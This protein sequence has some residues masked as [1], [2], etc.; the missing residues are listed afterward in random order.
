MKNRIILILIIA[1]AVLLVACGADIDRRV[2]FHRDE[3]WE[4]EML[5]RVPTGTLALVGSPEELEASFDEM[6]QQ[7]ESMDVRASWR[8]KVEGDSIL[9]TFKMNGQGFDK[10]TESVFDGSADISAVDVEGQRQIVFRDRV[11]GDILSA[12]SNTLTLEG[13]EILSSNGDQ[14]DKGTVQWINPSG[15]I[16]AVLTEKSGFNMAVLLVVVLFGGAAVAGVYYWRSG[17]QSE[18]A[19]P[20]CGTWLA[21]EAVFCPNCGQKR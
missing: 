8:S 6:I 11:F 17:R 5:L 20:N 15:R 19:C 7:A 21:K 16:E 13:G 14:L 4:A 2:T 1:S 9:Y 18:G 10:L 12:G 3:A